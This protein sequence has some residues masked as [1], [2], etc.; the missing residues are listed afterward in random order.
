[1]IV[2]LNFP[3]HIL[4][5]SSSKHSLSQFTIGEYKTRSQLTLSNFTRDDIGT[6]TCICKNAMTGDKDRVEGRVN[7]QLFQG[8]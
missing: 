3:G 6:Y 7:L 8:I 1:M 2:Y 5:E 4:S